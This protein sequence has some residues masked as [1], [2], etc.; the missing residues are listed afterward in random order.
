[1][2]KV[3]SI[4]LLAVISLLSYSFILKKKMAIYGIDKIE[5]NWGMVTPTLFASKYETTNKE[6]Q[7]F[8]TLPAYKYI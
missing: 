4:V 8:L 5:K 1:M 2:K 7:E 3:L 6:Y